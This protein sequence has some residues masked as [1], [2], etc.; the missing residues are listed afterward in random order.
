MAPQRQLLLGLDVGTTATK[1]AAFDLH[2]ASTAVATQPYG[3][4]TP[5]PGWVEQDP[6]ELWQAVVAAIREVLS[7]LG[8]GDRV[9][10]LS[11][12]SQGGTTIP[13]DE[14]GTPQH[15]AISWMDERGSRQAAAVRKRLGDEFVRR[16]TGWPLGHSLPLQHLGWLRDERPDVL[17]RASRV[18]FVNDFIVHRLAGRAVMNPSDATMTQLF[19]IAGCDW[20]ARL[21][22][23]VGLPRE[24]L[25]PVE[26]SGRAL[27]T[28]T[29]E[30]SRLTGL[31]PD[32]LVVNGAH[33]QYCAAIG[34][35]VTRP[36]TMLLSS[37][38]AW[39]ILAVPQDLETGLASG[40]SISCHAVPGRWGAIRSLGGVGTSLE[41]LARTLGSADPNPGG[42][43]PEAHP[44]DYATLNAAAARSEPGARGLLF[45]P[46]AGGHSRIGAGHGGFL[47]L[48]LEHTYG[49][50]A[51]AIMEGTSFELRWVLEEIRV[52]GVPVT[53]LTL[54]GGAA[55]SPLWPQIIASSAGVPVSLPLDRQAA[56]R[57]AAILAGVGVGVFPDMESGFERF[58]NQETL[59]HPLNSAYYET[60]FARYKA[61]YERVYAP[62]GETPL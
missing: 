35:G 8:S 33:D 10:A 60:A 55:T 12:A 4:T 6:L 61:T 17:D 51:R 24:K 45:Y 39:V 62:E 38:T 14:T 57:G 19:N 56:M 47:H 27:G 2:G 11:L 36:G 9:I 1:A 46:L 50:M 18:M 30:A 53:Q 49:D 44:T 42:G 29:E 5:R 3:L 15:P 13:V 23:A 22:D 25:S 31:S 21:L 40:M 48:A 16:T 7:Q 58:R 37:G 52:Y 28:V 34:T 41:W 20:E 54:V 32:T 43:R 59:L 26:H